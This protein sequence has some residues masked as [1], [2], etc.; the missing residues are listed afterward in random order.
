MIKTT[1]IDHYQ[2]GLAK[3]RL[4]ILVVISI[5]TDCALSRLVV[6]V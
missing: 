6:P 5:N 3:P 2:M 1:F 4:K